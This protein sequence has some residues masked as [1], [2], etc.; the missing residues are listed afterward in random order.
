MPL[1]ERKLRRPICIVCCFLCKN[2][3]ALQSQKKKKKIWK[4]TSKLLIVF[5]RRNREGVQGTLTHFS[6]VRTFY[7]VSVLI[8]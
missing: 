3:P 1:G 6:E 8:W 5:S 4:N 7:D 2:M